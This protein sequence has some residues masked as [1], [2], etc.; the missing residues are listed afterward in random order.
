MTR[1]SAPAAVAL[2]ALLAAGCAPTRIRPYSEAEMQVLCAPAGDLFELT[3]ERREGD[4][5]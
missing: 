4:R 3:R 5:L 1:A 2:V